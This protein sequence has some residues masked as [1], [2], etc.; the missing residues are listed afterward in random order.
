MKTY[1]EP[2]DKLLIFPGDTATER[3]D[4][5][6]DPRLTAP[7]SKNLGVSFSNR[8]DTAQKR[9]KNTSDTKCREYLYLE[10]LTAM[11]G[12]SFCPILSSSYAN[13]GPSRVLYFPLPGNYVYRFSKAKDHQNGRQGLESV[14]AEHENLSYAPG[15]SGD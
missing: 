15:D 5:S 11:V 2:V 9:S 1:P 8:S 4:M 14:A 12:W 3:H 10:F 13:G 6:R 7:L